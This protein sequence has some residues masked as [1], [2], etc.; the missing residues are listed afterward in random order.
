M[1][2][3]SEASR[4]K[5]LAVEPNHID[6]IYLFGALQAESGRLPEASANFDRVLALK[7]DFPEGL[8]TEAWRWGVWSKQQT[9]LKP[10]CVRTRPV[11]LASAAHFSFLMQRTH[12]RRSPDP[13]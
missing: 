9:A 11:A 6:A 5:I 12:R 8:A 1:L 4:A 10:S 3:Q 13:V 7:A 2:E